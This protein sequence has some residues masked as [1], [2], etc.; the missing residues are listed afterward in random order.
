MRHDRVNL[1]RREIEKRREKARTERYVLLPRTESVTRLEYAVGGSSGA[2]YSVVVDRVS[3][4]DQTCTCPDFTKSGLGTCKHIE[5]VRLA[6]GLATEDPPPDSRWDAP[7]ESLASR[8]YVLPPGIVC[9]D[10]ETLRLFAEVGGRAGIDRLGLAVAVTYDSTTDRYEAFL[11]P[12]AG[13]LI[14][15]LCAAR[16]VVGYN[17]VRFDYPVLQPYS[18]RRLDRLPT[19]DLLAEISRGLPQRPSL[20]TVGALTL[21]YGKSGHGLEAVEWFRQGQIDRVI[22]YCL[23]DVR[24]VRN[25]LG[26]ALENGYVR[27]L[28]GGRPT[29]VPT[30]DWARRIPR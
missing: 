21:G 18:P 9:F 10:V 3:I 12:Q 4:A 15:K 7:D 11:E 19:L 30:A 17:I 8:E 20:D 22:A 28:D 25:L 24:L 16:L 5:A 6:A 1:W 29:R 14:A 26:F 2:T 27:C 23:D 13:D